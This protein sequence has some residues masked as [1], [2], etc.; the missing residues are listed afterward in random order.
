[1]TLYLAVTVDADNDDFSV[2]DQR[3][4]LAWRGLGLIPDIAAA[5]HGFGWRVTWFVRGDPQI[6]AFYGSVAYLLETFASTWWQLKGD[7]DE[8]G[9]HPHISRL[10][11]AGSWEAERDDHRF[12]GALQET[13][14]DLRAQGFQLSSARMGEAAGSNLILKTL[15]DLGLKIDSSALPGRTRDDASRHFDWSLTPNYPYR[16]SLA[17]YRI[18]GMPSLPI[19]EVPMTTLP[20]TAQN[21][22]QPYLRYASLAYHPLIFM[23]SV[24]RWIARADGRRDDRIL[25]LI[26]H[27]DELMPRNTTHPLYAFSFS[28]LLSNLGALADFAK[29]QELEIAGVTVSD[30]ARISMQAASKSAQR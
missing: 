26:L 28:A 14:A 6:R 13:Y 12:V 18:A 21:E 27:P 7:G 11:A 5:I 16:P 8:I 23:D 2:S 22:Q 19:V 24:K 17:D 1:M 20:V 25:T 3:N 9:W 10:G 30:V 15:A 4:E 29:Q